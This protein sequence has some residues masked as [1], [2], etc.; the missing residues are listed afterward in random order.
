MQKHMMAKPSPNATL[1]AKT[2]TQSYVTTA[3]LIEPIIHN[4]TAQ[5]L[6]S[7]MASAT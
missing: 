1:K 2:E 3:S 4:T 5:S 6:T 7:E